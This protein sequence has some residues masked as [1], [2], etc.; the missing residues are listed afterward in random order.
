[1]TEKERLYIWL[2]QYGL[3]Q[4][5]S[6]EYQLKNF[7]AKICMRNIEILDLLQYIVCYS[8]REAFNTFYSDMMKI[9][10]EGEL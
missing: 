4:D 2:I 9:F 1:M 3:A 5:S 7:N 8:K 6:Y 10:K